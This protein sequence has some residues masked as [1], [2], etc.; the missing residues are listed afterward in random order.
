MRCLSCFILALLAFGVPSWAQDMLPQAEQSQ[1]N[2]I[3]RVNI[4]GYKS[5]SMCTGALIAPDRVL[6]AAH[7]LR[8][9]TG[10]FAPPEEVHFLAGWRLEKMAAH[11]RGA[12]ILATDP[13]AG[14][15]AASL[16]DLERDVAILVLDA[17]IAVEMVQPVAIGAP[18]EISSPLEIIAYQRRRPHAP[19][20]SSDCRMQ[21]RSNRLMQLTCQVAPGN[22]GGPVLLQRDG[23]A[24]IVGV[25]SA[26]SKKGAIAAIPDLEAL[27]LMS[28]K[29]R[30][31][32]PRPP[33]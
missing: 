22:S 1:W 14:A 12:A 33:D 24:E 7:C 16:D 8:G 5:R 10:D 4:A 29:T 11:R 20:R 23:G 2:A 21:S 18:P 9:P 27:E 6:T 32:S 30:P 26:N 15:R 25:I 31:R 17:P 3:G 13:D 28:R 19:S